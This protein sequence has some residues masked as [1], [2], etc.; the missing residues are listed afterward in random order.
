[1]RTGFRNSTLTVTSLV[2][3]LTTLT[4]AT[5]WT[6][7]NTVVDPKIIVGLT[8]GYAN[9]F[10]KATVDG[11]SGASQVDRKITDHGVS[12]GVFADFGLFN[13]GPGDLGFTTVFQLSAP[14]YYYDTG[15]WFRYRMDFATGNR[16]VPAVMP[17]I[18]LGFIAS[19]DNRLLPD[20]FIMAPSITLG[21]DLT[22]PVPGLIVGFGLD[23]DAVDPLGVREIRVLEGVQTTYTHRRDRITGLFRLGYRVF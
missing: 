22:T 4:P 17:Y 18:G 2:L 7:E 21:C 11:V 23:V 12:V 16:D 15:L 9:H 10:G 20:P 14:Q 1:M 5:L 6:Q 8:F 19:F 13:A 3:F